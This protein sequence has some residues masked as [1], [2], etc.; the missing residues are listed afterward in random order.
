MNLVGRP[1]ADR[2]FEHLNSLHAQAGRRKLRGGPFALQ[3]GRSLATLSEWLEYCARLA[4]RPAPCPLPQKL[5][6]P[7][8][9]TS[10]AKPRS[11]LSKNRAIPGM[12]L[13]SK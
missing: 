7:E 1:V 12:V 3:L 11:Q 8:H 10:A 4:Q 2:L 6:A 5:P 13:L 9:A